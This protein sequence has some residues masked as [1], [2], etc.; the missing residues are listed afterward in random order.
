MKSLAMKP[1]L[2]TFFIICSFELIAQE[3]KLHIQGQIT[4]SDKIPIT[5]AYVI[6]L[7]DNSQHVSRQNG[8]FDIWLLPTDSIM[9]THVTYLRKFISTF[10]LLKNPV[11]V[12][13]PDTVS[14]NQ[15]NVYTTK[16]TDYQRAME[17]INEIKYDPR[18]QVNDSYSESERMQ[19]LLQRENKV[20]RA[21]ANSL[22]YSFSPTA[23]IGKIVD[24]IKLRKKSKQY[25]S[26]KRKKK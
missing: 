8:V 3:E 19:Q 18:P 10:D 6:N 16:K 15:V 13:E 4:D 20:E 11:I 23:V 24:K 14:I 9:I 12:L 21:A 22:T 25:N 2:I 7:H 1:L 17:N 26:T 5:D